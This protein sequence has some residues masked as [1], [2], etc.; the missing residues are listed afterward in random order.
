MARR[1]CLPKSRCAAR[2]MLM[3]TRNR[4]NLG[5]RRPRN[6]GLSDEEALA[7]RQPGCRSALLSFVTF[8]CRRNAQPS[9]AEIRCRLVSLVEPAGPRRPHRCCPG[10]TAGCLLLGLTASAF[11]RGR[12][13]RSPWAALCPIPNRQR[14][15]KS[16]LLCPAKCMG[17]KCK[18]LRRWLPSF[19]KRLA[20]SRPEPSNMLYL[21]KL[22]H[23]ASR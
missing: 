11:W 7:L 21:N 6:T 4:R 22:G 9:L 8:L 14:F 20:S 5:A 23:S 18:T 19:W 10:R 17:I 12:R 13:R 15:P 2:S 1:S 16:V 3:A